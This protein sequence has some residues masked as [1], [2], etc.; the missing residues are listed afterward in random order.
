MFALLVLI[1]LAGLVL[2]IKGVRGRVIGDDHHC[3]TCGFNLRGHGPESERCPECG[4]ELRAATV[5][6]GLLQRSR[7][8]I[9]TGLI[10]TVVGGTLP[11]IAALR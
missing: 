9:A 11:T 10:L 2:L 7:A 4:T 8:L 5:R 3:R 6:I 1:A